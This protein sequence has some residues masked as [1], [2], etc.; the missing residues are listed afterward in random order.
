MAE[1]FEI[2]LLPQGTVL[3]YKEQYFVIDAHM[4]LL[5]EMQGAHGEQV[6]SLAPCTAQGA[7]TGTATEV[8]VTCFVP[9]LETLGLL[10]VV[11]K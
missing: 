6:Y 2:E 1:H 9:G 7:V 11:D 10:K 4:S 8:L 3:F 5:P